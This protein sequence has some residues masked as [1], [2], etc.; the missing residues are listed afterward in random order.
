M[1]WHNSSAVAVF[2]KTNI[3]GSDGP[4]HTDSDYEQVLVIESV[5]TCNCCSYFTDQFN[6]T[7]HIL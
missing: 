2:F 7:E 3:P 5:S 1:F 4:G 6:R